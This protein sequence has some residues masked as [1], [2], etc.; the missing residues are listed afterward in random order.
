MTENCLWI[1]GPTWWV[2]EC[3]PLYGHNFDMGSEKYGPKDSHFEFCPYCGKHIIEDTP[4]SGE[5]NH[6]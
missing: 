2:P 1:R 5:G 3:G 4:N 6:G